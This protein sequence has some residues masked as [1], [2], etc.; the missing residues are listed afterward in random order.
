[1]P[2]DTVLS[3]GIKINNQSRWVKLYRKI[4]NLFISKELTHVKDVDLAFKQLD[5]RVTALEAAVNASMATMGAQMTAINAVVLSHVHPV[6]TA[7][8][9]T[10][11]AGIAAP[12]PTPSPPP[13]PPAP[14]ATGPVTYQ[15]TFMKAE[16]AKWFGMG[17]ALAPFSPRTT[18][19]DTKASTSLTST[20]GV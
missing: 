1:M 14:A 4:H 5:A 11:Q 20:I 2:L 19:D 15:E 9:P 16:D 3:A 10:N 12:T 8:G 17:P 7:G 13:P 18:L 6:T